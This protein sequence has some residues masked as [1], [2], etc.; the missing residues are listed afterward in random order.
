MFDEEDVIFSYSR[1]DA[2]NDGSLV[3]V[4]EIGKEA[5][6]KFPIAVTVKLME[7]YIKPSKEMENIGQSKNGRLWDVLHMFRIAAIKSSGTDLLYFKVLFQ[8]QINKEPELVK[9]KGIC[10]PGDNHEPV[11]TLM[12][13]VED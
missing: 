5:G 1:A 3:D 12:L 10:H 13:P 8:M 7:Q 11:I 2:L 6:I 9:I 4:T